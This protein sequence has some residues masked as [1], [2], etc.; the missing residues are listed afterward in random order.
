MR[1]IIGVL[2]LFNSNNG[3][4][5]INPAY[6]DGVEAAGGLPV[7]LTLTENE[8]ALEQ[9]CTGFDGFVFTGGQDIHPELYNEEAI[10]ECDY[11]VWNRD[12]QELWMLRRLLELDKPVLGVCRGCQMMNIALGGSLYQ[13]IPV[14]LAGALA[15][16]QAEPYEETC[17]EVDIIEGSLLHKTIGASRLRVN[18]IHHQGV[19]SLGSGLTASAIAPDGLIEAVEK[20][21]NRLYLGVQWHPEYL[22]RRDERAGKIFGLLVDQAR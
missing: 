8:D 1:P 5:W 17:H 14:Q 16:R 3:N 13:D 15:H 19:K 7:L 12:R 18:S 9:Y 2:P 10:P 11:Q 6:M 22:W 20:P 4:Y 21:G